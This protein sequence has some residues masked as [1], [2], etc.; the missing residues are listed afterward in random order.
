MK[1][2]VKNKIAWKV[3]RVWL[4]KRIIPLFILELVLLTLALWILGRLVFVQQVFTNAFLASAQNP[5]ILA[6]YMFKAFWATSILKKIIILIFLSFGILIM[7]DVGRV[8]NSYITTSRVA[9]P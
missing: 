8:F 7:R 2:V 1:D 6:S 9:K 3:Y 5:L 4:F